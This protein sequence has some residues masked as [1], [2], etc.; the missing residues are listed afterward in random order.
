MNT[1]RSIQMSDEIKNPNLDP[2]EEDE[3]IEL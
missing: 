3:L 2:D 1:E